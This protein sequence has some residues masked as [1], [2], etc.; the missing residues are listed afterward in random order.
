[1]ATALSCRMVHGVSASY[2]LPKECICPNLL[3][4]SRKKCLSSSSSPI[5]FYGE[6]RPAGPRP[7]SFGAAD[8][9]FGDGDRD[10]PPILVRPV[11][12]RENR[13]CRSLALTALSDPTRADAV[14]ALGEVTG[15]I[16]WQGM[17]QRMLSDPTGQ[18]IFAQPP[19]SR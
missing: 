12:P 1:M 17:H 4:Y 14:A 15:H 5:P 6:P 11:S 13:S 8:S 3:G 18:R 19:F 2:L 7:S 10:Q 16:A 9:S